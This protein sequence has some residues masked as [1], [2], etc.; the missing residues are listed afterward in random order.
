[1]SP[2]PLTGWGWVGSVLKI[3]QCFG[4]RAKV[5]F[6]IERCEFCSM[7]YGADTG[8]TTYEPGGGDP[9]T[10]VSVDLVIQNRGAAETTLRDVTI[11][12]KNSRLGTLTLESAELPCR[13][14]TNDSRQLRSLESTKKGFVPT[15][16]RSIS[17]RLQ[18]TFGHKTMRKRVPIRR[19][20]S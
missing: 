9:Y 20:S 16:T 3:W 14:R 6:E 10:T 19:V 4:K 12:T 11:K 1:M 5:S 18:L 17:G 8:K 7:V 2:E 13:V 15:K